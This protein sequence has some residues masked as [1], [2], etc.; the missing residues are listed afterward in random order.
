M[1]EV[2]SSSEC[3]GKRRNSNWQEEME[4][5]E[6]SSVVPFPEG[7]AAWLRDVWLADRCQ[8]LEPLGA[9]SQSQA[10]T[11]PLVAEDQGVTQR[12]SPTCPGWDSSEEGPLRCVS[13]GAGR[14]SGLHW[15]CPTQLPSFS[16]HP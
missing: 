9:I 16:L 7:L 1:C 5:I 10:Q 4:D 15:V 12:L 8:L 14:D 13:C 3:M 6:V 2:P 11:L